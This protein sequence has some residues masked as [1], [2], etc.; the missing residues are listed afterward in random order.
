MLLGVFGLLMYVSIAL[1]KPDVL[2]HEVTDPPIMESV[3][4][5]LG[6]IGLAAY[7]KGVEKGS[8]PLIGLF[9]SLALMFLAY[10]AWQWTEV[11]YTETVIASMFAQR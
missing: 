1:G 10:G 5:V 8:H 2:H 7:L 3:L 4:F 11:L 6:V 9:F